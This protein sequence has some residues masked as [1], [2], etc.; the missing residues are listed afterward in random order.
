MLSELVKNYIAYIT[1]RSAGVIVG[2]ITKTVGLPESLQI[3]TKPT[4]R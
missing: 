1:Q 2:N 4:V 3:L